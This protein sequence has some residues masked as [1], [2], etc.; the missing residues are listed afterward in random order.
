[1]FGKV[2]VAKWLVIVVVA[3]SV[4]TW[5]LLRDRSAWR[6][7]DS[8]YDPPPEYDSFRQEPVEHPAFAV[9][10]AAKQP[11]AQL[12]LKDAAFRGL[13]AAE[14]NALLGH[15]LRRKVGQE[16]YLVRGVSLI[17]GTG[18]FEVIASLDQLLV[19]HGCSGRGPVEMKRKALVVLLGKPPARVFVDCHMA[20]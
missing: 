12:L 11:S 19:A 15:E 3:L 9:V 10:L 2:K 18:R 13:E 16:Y 14:A 8:W 20:E 6:T 1:M 4:L 7:A 5:A 17:E